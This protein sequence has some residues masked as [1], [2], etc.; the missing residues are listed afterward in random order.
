LIKLKAL[1]LPE[2]S[3]NNS[4]YSADAGEPDTGWTASGKKRMLGVDNNKPEPWFEKGGY[5]QIEFPKA[6]D[7]YDVSDGRG[8]DKSI[9]KFQVVKRVINTGEKYTDFENEKL[10]W[11]LYEKGLVASWDKYGGKKYS[12]KD[13]K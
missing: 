12:T 10:I 11:D 7:P 13:I 3:S 8:A 5:T 1:L 2:I 4:S 9:Q 6:D